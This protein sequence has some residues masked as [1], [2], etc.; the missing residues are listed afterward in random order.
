MK[1]IIDYESENVHPGPFSLDK[2][3]ES[4]APG[5]LSW[6]R[7]EGNYPDSDIL[8]QREIESGLVAPLFD[9]SRMNKQVI[10]CRVLCT[11]CK[12]WQIQSSGK[13]A[14]PEIN[15]AETK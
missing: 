10:P 8:P 15:N 9:G 7:I 13:V 11:G 4:D 2:F 14:L 5:T 12:R 1:N 6:L 3:F